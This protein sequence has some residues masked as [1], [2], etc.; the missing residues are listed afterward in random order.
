VYQGIDVVYYGTAGQLEYDFVVAP[1]ANP[2]QIVMQ[3]SGADKLELAKDGDLVLTAGGEKLYQKPPVLY[4]EINGVRKS[5]SGNYVIK[6]TNQVSFNIGQYDKSQTLII[7][8]VISYATYLGGAG[9]EHGESIAVDSSGYAYITG[10]TSEGGFPTTAGVYQPNYV[11][12]WDV[13][14][15]KL[16]PN[17]T[18]VVYST[19]LGGSGDDNGYGIAIDGSGNAYVSGETSS[20]NFP[21]TVGAYDTTKNSNTDAFITKLNPSGTA[22]VYSS[23]F[24]G[25]GVDYANSIAVDS[26]GNA[27]LAGFTNSTNLPVAGAYQSSRSGS[28]MPL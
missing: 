7:D 26:S 21:T 17:G 20:A 4:Q 10:A 9:I 5:V 14:V 12:G 16:N 15:T 24:G 23:Y 11:G 18:S 1:N 6:N 25:S 13:F 19:Y 27:Y 3:F 8:P 22:L 28:T 2:N